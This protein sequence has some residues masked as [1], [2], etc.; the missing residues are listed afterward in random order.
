M[1]R[2][3]SLHHFVLMHCTINT[4]W[5]AAFRV[6]QH[7]LLEWLRCGARANTMIQF[8]A[9]TVKVCDVLNRN[10]IKLCVCWKSNALYVHE[11]HV[12]THLKLTLT[13][14]ERGGGTI[15]FCY[16]FSLFAITS[17]C[18]EFKRL[19]SLLLLL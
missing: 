10:I 19:L 2:I 18:N 3:V 7:K 12:K 17:E 6:T 15:L 9:N 8:T 14:A 4:I 13:E 16:Y 5:C 11:A 1:S